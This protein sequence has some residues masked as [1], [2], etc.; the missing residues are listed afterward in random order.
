MVNN[1]WSIIIRTFCQRNDTLIDSLYSIV[2][3]PFSNKEIIIVYDIRNNDEFEQTKALVDHFKS[4]LPIKEFQFNHKDKNNRG[5]MHTFINTVV[6]QLDSEFISFLDDD[7]VYYP[8]FSKLVDALKDDSSLTFVMGDYIS[9]QNESMNDSMFV[10]A[11]NSL[12]QGG[13]NRIK[14]YINNYIPS[15]TFVIRASLAKKIKFNTSLDILED[16]AFLIDLSK[17]EDFK[18]RYISEFVSEYRKYINKSHTGLE[19]IS[20]TNTEKKRLEIIKKHISEAIFSVP[21]E[22]VSDFIKYYDHELSITKSKTFK[23]FNRLV[24][25]KYIK[26]IFN[27][28]ESKFEKFYFKMKN[29]PVTSRLI[30]K[31]VFFAK[32]RTTQNW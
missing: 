5:E 20:D 4:F 23:I 28:L 3:Q 30:T 7:D 32:R 27:S 2:M 25:N 26:K 24:Q 21:G 11:K 19:H 9:S 14:L 31:V 10:K 18:P 1:K 12:V 6:P 8:T 13:Y 29:S 16:W 15:N 17:D 22:E